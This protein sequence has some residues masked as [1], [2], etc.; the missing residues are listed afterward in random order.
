M[1]T[2]RVNENFVPLTDQNIKSQCSYNKPTLIKIG[3][4]ID[5]TTGGSGPLGDVT[6]PTTPGTKQW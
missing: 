6:G 2:N 4:V 3:L 5:L 1:E